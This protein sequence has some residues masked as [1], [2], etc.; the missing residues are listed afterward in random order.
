MAARQHIRSQGF[1]QVFDDVVDI[2]MFVLPRQTQGQIAKDACQQPLPAG[3]RKK[4]F[5]QRAWDR[6]ET[7]LW[8][9]TENKQP[10][11]SQRAV[12]K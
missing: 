7:T 11:G 10:L 8:L 3:I 6:A 5:R 1:G 2:T 4:V 9:R 12:V